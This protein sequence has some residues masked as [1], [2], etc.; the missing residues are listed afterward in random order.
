VPLPR[1]R[2][3]VRLANDATYLECRAAVVDF[4]HRRHGNPER[5]QVAAQ[6]NAV[7]DASAAEGSDAEAATRAAA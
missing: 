5:S 1:P 7:L 2:D 4:L 6:A 3:R